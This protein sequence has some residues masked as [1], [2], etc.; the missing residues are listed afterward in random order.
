MLPQAGSSAETTWKDSKPWWFNPEF[1][2][3]WD[4]LKGPK[5]QLVAILQRTGL[6]QIGKPKRQKFSRVV[7]KQQCA[8]GFILIMGRSFSCR[9]LTYM[10]L[11][12][13]L[14]QWRERQRRVHVWWWERGIWFFSQEQTLV[15]R[16]FF[17]SFCFSFCCMRGWHQGRCTDRF[18][19]RA[20]FFF[21]FS[22]FFGSTMTDPIWQAVGTPSHAH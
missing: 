11:V 22:S 17:F 13:K 9:A 18:H 4:D 7:M 20:Q 16:V 21:L 12:Q 3:F 10:V 14:L 5:F 1:S 2:L 15:P 19:W 6:Q 8:R